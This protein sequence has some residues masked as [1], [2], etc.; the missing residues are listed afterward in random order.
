MQPHD[1]SR[2][3][4]LALRA[5]ATFS[6]VSGSVLAAG[7][8]FLGPW[9]GIPPLALAAVGLV[10]LPFAWLLFRNAAR[11]PISQPEARLAVGADVAWVVGSAALLTC[12]PLGLS[13]AGRVAVVVVALC[14]AHFALLQA[15][16]LGRLRRAPAVA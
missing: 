5:N 1:P 14:V 2:P 4:R 9:L 6:T 7:A 3:L 15:L 12:D 16:G 8:P 11:T 13:Q 10:L